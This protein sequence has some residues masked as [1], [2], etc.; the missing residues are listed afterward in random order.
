MEK[1]IPDGYVEIFCRYI[2][3]KGKRVI[4]PQGKLYHF[5]ARPKQKIA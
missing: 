5:Y 2:T 1:N 4:H 3:I